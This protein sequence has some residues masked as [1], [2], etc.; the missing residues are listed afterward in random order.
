MVEA[1]VAA[2][3]GAGTGTGTG[4]KTGAVVAMRNNDRKS[5][6]HFACWRRPEQTDII[7]KAPIAI[8]MMF[9]TRSMSTDATKITIAVATISAL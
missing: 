6:L 1:I 8:Q 3:S 4:T 5:V 2:G 9:T 7:L